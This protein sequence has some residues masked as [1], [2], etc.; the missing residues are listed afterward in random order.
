MS[1]DSTFDPETFLNTSIDQAMETRYTT[2]PAAEYNAFIADISA[3]TM[4]INGQASTLLDIDYM[5][6]DEA[7]ASKL[8]LKELKVRQGIFLDVGPDGKTLLFGPNKNVRLGR[9]REAVRQ[10]QPNKPWS[11][12]MLRG[13]GPVK[14]TVEVEPDKKDPTVMYNRVTKVVAG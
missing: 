2:L 10:N 13:A 9:V 12:G 6:N 14:I 4:Q 8:N 7:L 5:I 11:F 1:T 3:R